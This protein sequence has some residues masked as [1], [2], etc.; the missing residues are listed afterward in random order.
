MKLITIGK[1][2][3]VVLRLSKGEYVSDKELQ[4]SHNRLLMSSS[5]GAGKAMKK[6]AES[7]RLKVAKHL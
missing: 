6:V 5:P 1:K 4:T 7:M 2:E 3:S